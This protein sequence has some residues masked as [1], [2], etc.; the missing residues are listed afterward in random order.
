MLPDR[1]AIAVLLCTSLL[2]ATDFTEWT[3][4]PVRQD[5]FAMGAGTAISRRRIQVRPNR[6][7]ILS[8]E[9]KAPA[10]SVLYFGFRELDAQLRPILTRTVNAASNAFALPREIPAGATEI[11]VAEALSRLVRGRNDFLAF[12][13]QDDYSDLP[14][15]DLAAIEAAEPGR[16]RL[17]APLAKGYPAHTKV[18]LHRDRA[19]F[20]YCAAAGVTLTGEW[21]RFEGTVTGRQK[22]GTRDQQWRPGSAFAEIVI[23]YRPA[24]GQTAELQFRD[25]RIDAAP[26]RIVAGGQPAAEA[27]YDARRWRHGDGL[28]RNLADNQSLDAEPLY[29]TAR[30]RVQFTL[31]LDRLADTGCGLLA[32]NILWTLDGPGGNLTVQGR[33]FRPVVLAKAADFIQPGRPFTFTLEGSDADRKMRAAIDGKPVGEATYLVNRTL[34]FGLRTGKARVAL[35]EF[36]IQ[37]DIPDPTDAA[38]PVTGTVA[39]GQDAPLRLPRWRQP[40]LTTTATL[41]GGAP[42]PLAVDALGNA[43]LPRAVLQQAYQASPVPYRVR[44]LALAVQLPDRQFYR[45]RIPVDNPALSTDLPVGKVVKTPVGNRL[46]VGGK[47]WNFYQSHWDY[48]GRQVL[49]RAFDPADVERFANAGMRGS[50]LILAPY[51]YLGEKDYDCDGMIQE[52]ESVAARVVAANPGAMFEIQFFLFT[53]TEWNDRHQDELIRLDNGRKHLAHAFRAELQP[54]Y[55]SPAWRRD[56]G[57]VVRQTVRALRK[58]PY[59]D[60]IGT[61]RLLYANCGEWNHWGYH[62][63]AYVDYSIPM[64]RA[65]GKWLKAKYQTDDALQK[66]WGRPG[67]TF[68]SDDLVPS[69]EN[70]LAGG[71]VL[72]AN[73]P[74]GMPSVDYY[75]FFQQ[76]TVDTITHF[77][78]IAKEASDNRLLVGSY[79][80]YF[81][82]HYFANPYH[83]QDSGN[84]ATGRML[85]S[86]FIDF[87]GGAAPYNRRDLGRLPNGLTASIALHGKVWVDE[88]DLRT[89]R[90]DQKPNPHLGIAERTQSETSASLA[91]DFMAVVSRNATTYLYDFIAGWY[92]DPETMR[93]ISRLIALDDA[94]RGL[95]AARP[96]AAQVALVYSEAPIPYN[97]S[98]HGAAMGH[99]KFSSLSLDY[100]G[101]PADT[102]LESDLDRIDFTPYRA[103]VFVNSFLYTDELQKTIA[104]KVA[105]DGRTLVFLGAP[106]VLTPD[107]RLHPENSARLAGIRVRWL[108]EPMPGKPLQTIWKRTVC[109]A[110]YTRFAEIRDDQ[111]R[112][113]AR[114]PDGAVAAAERT[115][116]GCRRIV[117]CHPFPD[118]VLMRDLLGRAGVHIYTSGKSGLPAAYVAPPYL[119]VFSRTGGPQTITLPR[120]VEVIADLMSGA[121]LAENAKSVSFDLPR[122]KAATRLLYAGPRQDFEQRLKPLLK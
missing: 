52:F 112:P 104:A 81:H 39:L 116:D 92:R 45:C 17:K 80:G 8:G 119:G 98:R 67:V 76:Y 32:G 90:S 113:L 33:D 35:R 111:A 84:Y 54:S 120:P 105:K 85:E 22:A 79:Y 100:W 87:F 36:S 55:A 96:T 121:V 57:E 108:D 77:A 28:L 102:Y 107:N 68:A 48:N 62:E 13:A 50:L 27:F 66:A 91:R 37:G 64:Q 83:F 4:A 19:P 29:D 40:R 110:Q 46:S 95:S 58:S 109:N 25:I 14:N 72:R 88:G 2:L 86:P 16:I 18:R 71:P 61:F 106:G 118:A 31:T 23:V 41:D 34:G 12:H 78:R 26:D 20:N 42:F 69:R 70:R 24:P 44:P 21:Q 30:F 49:E 3:G 59:A 38:I 73:G 15:A 56:M 5:V 11:P 7:C 9:F 47:V 97:A 82:G 74:A 6:P 53:S 94:R 114:F 122:G 10:G 89:H 65:F 93:V 115:V 63:Q 75:A 1:A 117:V 103:V 101:I 99:E 51:K 43:A 60:R